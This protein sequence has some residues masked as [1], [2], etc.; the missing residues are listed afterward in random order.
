ML[1]AFLLYSESARGLSVCLY[2]EVSWQWSAVSFPRVLRYNL[3]ET[4]F[5]IYPGPRCRT[6]Y[7]VLRIHSFMAGIFFL[8]IV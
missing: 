8:D 1:E 4:S 7:T 5:L 6:I 3:F 2:E